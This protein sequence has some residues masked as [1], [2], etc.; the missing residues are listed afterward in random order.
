MFKTLQETTRTVRQGYAIIAFTREEPNHLSPY[1][2]QWSPFVAWICDDKN[3]AI[4][5]AKTMRKLSLERGR[6]DCHFIVQSVP[7]QGPCRIV[8]ENGD[9]TGLCDDVTIV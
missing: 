7:I 5:T 9:C 6:T 1:P 2:N 3:V 4:E 8:S